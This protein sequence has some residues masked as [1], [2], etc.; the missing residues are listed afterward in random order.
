M[1]LDE[2]LR[3]ENKIAIE[4]IEAQ[5]KKDLKRETKYAELQKSW[6]KLDKKIPHIQKLVSEI[7]MHVQKLAKASNEL[8]EVV[9]EAY[10]TAPRVDISSLAASP[11]GANKIWHYLKIQFIKNGLKGLGT[12]H[13]VHAL[14]GFS[15]NMTEGLLWLVKLKE[16]DHLYGTATERAAK[17][18]RDRA[19]GK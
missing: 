9:A 14:K 10:Y 15:Q 12:I 2:N 19:N 5:I 6:E 11:L 1:K 18:A 4:K 16:G 8:N 7:E 17:L 3:P 13:N